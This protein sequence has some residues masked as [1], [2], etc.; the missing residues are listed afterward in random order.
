MALI[1][2]YVPTDKITESGKFYKEFQVDSDIPLDNSVIRVAPPADLQFPKYNY[3]TGIWTEDKDSII[4]ETK[5]QNKSVEERMT[6]L[7]NAL[8]EITLLFMGASLPTEGE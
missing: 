1:T 6:T 2:I 4:N 3:T 5:N 8:A 7:E